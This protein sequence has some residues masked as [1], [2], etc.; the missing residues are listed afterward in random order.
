MF[1]TKFSQMNIPQLLVVGRDNLLIE[2]IQFVFK[3]YCKINVVSRFIDLSNQEQRL[4]DGV[5]L[6]HNP[7]EEDGFAR[8]KTIKDK[9][10]GLPLCL[11]GC[12]MTEQEQLKAYQ[13]GARCAINIKELEGYQP[14]ILKALN[15]YADIKKGTSQLSKFPKL[16]LNEEITKAFFS[17]TA[18]TFTNKPFT[19]QPSYDLS[20]QMLGEFKAILRGKTVQH[21]L[22][23]K[24]KVVL[25]YLMMNRKKRLLRD[26][27]AKAIW[28]DVPIEF[29][30]NNLNVTIHTLRK[31]FH[32]IDAETNYIISR[33]D[34][35]EINQSL[36]IETDVDY[37]ITAYQAAKVNSTNL[38]EAV[39]DYFRAY[40]NYR[41]AFMED[42]TN[43]EWV[44]SE[45]HNLTELFL[46]VLENMTKG[47]IQEEQYELAL[48][49]ALK[50]IQLDNCLEE[51]YRMG[52]TCHWKMQKRVDALRLFEKCKTA[53]KSELGV[54]VSSKTLELKERIEKDSLPNAG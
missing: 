50:M 43:E 16:S 28:K 17:I 7:P 54:N 8:L 12:N 38:S 5:L 36:K 45:R 31:W 26:N 35:Y 24:A 2:K 32:G 52:M 41:G 3:S 44:E 47:F 42:I 48:K 6:I 34:Y 37:F 33:G 19:S 13:T 1:V 29:A 10:E 22:T 51:A 20:I 39:T 4:I 40:V 53:L 18:N 11:V 21:T 23:N 30:K 25:A 15:L 9:N 27:L 49:G 46:K 14:Q